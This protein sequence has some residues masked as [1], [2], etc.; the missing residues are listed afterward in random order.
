[1][2][3]KGSEACQILPIITF[4]CCSSFPVL[5]FSSFSS[6]EKRYQITEVRTG[7]PS[8]SVP[9]NICSSGNFLLAGRC[10]SNVMSL[11]GKCCWVSD[12]SGCLKE[13]DVWN[14][15]YVLCQK[16]LPH[17]PPPPPLNTQFPIATHPS[18]LPEGLNFALWPHP[19][20]PLMSGHTFAGKLPS[21]SGCRL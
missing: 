19:N 8:G 3:V 1:M 16:P 15:C 20:W 14:S 18:P 6:L 5:L 21:K 11:E 12:N 13:F 4:V 9:Q 10:G 7:A 17:S 2:S